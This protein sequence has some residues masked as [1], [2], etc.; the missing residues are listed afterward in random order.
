MEGHRPE[1][2]VDLLP[3]RPRAVGAR[4]CKCQDAAVKIIQ[5]R[6]IVAEPTVRNNMVKNSRRVELNSVL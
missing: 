3:H 2:A 4:E 6:V 5:Q 1:F